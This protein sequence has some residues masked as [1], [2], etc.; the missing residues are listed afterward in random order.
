M[1]RELETVDLGDRVIFIGGRGQQQV[2]LFPH[3]QTIERNSIYFAIDWS[4]TTW[5]SGVFSLT[6]K[7]IKPLT[8][9][10]DHS[11]KGFINCTLWF[12]PKPW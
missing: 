1:G 9:P 2:H 8:F 6:N 3:D 5:E 10:K 4:P 12:T 11:H 7:S